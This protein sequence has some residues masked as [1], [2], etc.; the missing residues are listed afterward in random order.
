[1]ELGPSAPTPRPSVSRACPVVKSVVV[2]SV[3]VKSVIV[4]SVVVKSVVVKSVVVSVSGSK[5]QW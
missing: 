5:R 4:K 1:L 2:K 3:V